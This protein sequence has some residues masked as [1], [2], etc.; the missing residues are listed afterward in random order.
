[1]LS[2]NTTDSQGRPAIEFNYPVDLM[3]FTLNYDGPLSSTSRNSRLEEKQQIRRQ[4]HWQLAT[5]YAS[6]RTM[7]EHWPVGRWRE[8]P[9]PDDILV[10]PV[11]KFTF[12]PL[13]TRAEYLLCDLDILFLRHED[14]GSLVLPG[15]DLDNRLTTLFDALQVPQH[16]NELPENDCPA[17]DET[18]LHCLLENDALISGVN[19][20]TSRLLQ[21]VGKDESNQVRLVID[22]T[23]KITMLTWNNS[24]FI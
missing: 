12:I 4:V 2:A 21:T 17:P 10:R 1:M 15:G 24:I 9:P 22:V 11:G 3:R 8:V 5:L 13:V 20:R 16:A 23:V 19:V 14:A 18:P 6:D 7:R